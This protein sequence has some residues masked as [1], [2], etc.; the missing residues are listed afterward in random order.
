MRPASLAASTAL[1]GAAA[2]ASR[3]LGFLRDILLAMLLGSGPAADAFVVAFRLPSLLRRILGEGGLNAGVVPVAQRL[4]A[5]E[6]EAAAGRFAG[7]ALGVSALALAV[8]VAAGTVLAPWIVLVLAPG[9]AEDAARLDTAVSCLRLVLPLVLTATLA[10]LASALLNAQNRFAAAAL[11]PL[12]VNAVLV[13]V[14]LALSRSGLPQEQLAAILA[15]AVSVA[16]LAQLLALLPALRRLPARPAWTMPRL[17]PPLLRALSLGLPGLA[18][19]T[20]AQLGVVVATMVASRSPEAVARLYY[21]ERLYQLPLGFVAAAAGVVLLPEIARRLVAGDAEGVHPLQNRA[22]ELALALALP[23][24]VALAMLAG[25]I[26]SVLFERG[27][28]DAADAASTAAALAALG[29]GLPGAAATRVLSQPFFARERPRAPLAC[30]ALGLIATAAVA[31]ALE[32]GFGAAGVAAGVSAGAW[33]GALALATVALRL[34]WWRLDHS[35]VPRLLRIAAACAGMAAVLWGLER[36]A[37]PW[38]VAGAG[39]PKRA[40]ALAVL[41]LGGGAAY[42]ALAQ[43][44]RALDLRELTG[45]A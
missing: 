34:G 3:I 11:A 44:L 24:A 6:G 33:T 12:V 2:A 28:F 19:M 26:V 23:A 4:Q 21:A 30:A 40:A 1:V 5:E 16:G 29:L 43:V 42:L 35:T 20:L 37:A 18:A 25:P 45:R 7:E 22:L 27:A 31:A 8:L 10:A 13:A 38:L 17:S 36:L 41:C 14:L 32:A 9:F 39:T 15:A